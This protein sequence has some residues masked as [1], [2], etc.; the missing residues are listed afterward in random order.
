MKT[1][2]KNKIALTKL[3]QYLHIFFLC[4]YSHPLNAL[5]NFLLHPFAQ[6]CQSTSVNIF[7]DRRYSTNYSS[8]YLSLLT[9]SKTILASRPVPYA[10]HETGLCPDYAQTDDETRGQLILQS[11]KLIYQI[12]G[13]RDY[14]ICCAND[15]DT[16][17]V[18]NQYSILN[19]NVLRGYLGAGGYSPSIVIA[20]PT[21]AA[22]GIF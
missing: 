13:F 18:E 5:N 2:K 9:G 17:P 20:N 6:R 19:S 14:G 8:T 16:T 15:E 22:P 12:G 21:I 4:F 3:S 11:E 10:I 1:E 7:V